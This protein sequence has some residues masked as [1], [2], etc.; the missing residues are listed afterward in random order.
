M[1]VMKSFQ[2]SLILFLLLTITFIVNEN[3]VDANPMHKE[4][5]KV[6]PQMFGGMVDDM[7]DDTDAIRKASKYL[8]S[9]GG[10]TLYF[11]KGEY[12]VSDFSVYANGVGYGAVDI[13]S[14]ITYLGEKGTVIKVGDNAGKKGV[15]QGVFIGRYKENTTNIVFKK[16]E[17]DLNGSNN[18]FPIELY[19][20]TKETYCC[21]AIRTCYPKNIIIEECVFR[22]CPG[23]NCLALGYAEGA[24]VKN[25]EF[26]NNADAIDGNKV[27][28]H[29]CILVAGGNVQ[30]ISNT[31]DEYRLSNV[32]T[33]IEIN[34]DNSV[35]AN[36][37]AH[38]YKVACLIS[39]VGETSVRNVTVTKNKFED[40]QVAVQ[41]WSQP[42]RVVKGVRIIRNNIMG[43][44]GYSLGR[45]AI[46]LRTYAREEISDV[47]IKDNSIT[48]DKTADEGY[49]GAILL[50]AGN[51]N[52]SIVKNTIR[53]FTGDAVAIIGKVNQVR[54]E[55]NSI[56][57]CSKS[58]NATANRV[59][60]VNSEQ[61]K[62]RD[63]QIKGN[64]MTNGEKEN[65]KAIWVLN[66]CEEIVI[67][68]NKINGFKEIYKIDNGLMQ[69]K[70]VTIK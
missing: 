32:A 61:D 65:N 40:N 69:T 42:N 29:S 66:N 2:S 55:Y 6:T 12:L 23:L 3:N 39:P 62:V 58:L 70:K 31:F 13:Y 21:S 44:T 18:Y 17:F 28:D 56:V 43:L 10:G 59:V 49:Y 53:G 11:P 7:R 14:N 48:L 34:A 60:L 4:L 67:D 19:H 9:I 33:A 47:I 63:V 38:H 15:W 36:N 50:G 24:I 25:N 20:K 68:G 1:F 46:D 5:R 16:I 30:V 37:Y 64:K 45:Y 41:V 57:D 52:V 54:I 35:V 27:Y 26:N 51:R 8:N 22:N